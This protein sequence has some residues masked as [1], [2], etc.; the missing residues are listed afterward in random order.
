MVG[1]VGKWEGG[2]WFWDFR[3]RHSFLVWEEELPAKLLIS[4][5]GVVKQELVDTWVWLFDLTKGFASSS[6]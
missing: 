1:S 6:Y 2:K 5:V 4:I 3:W